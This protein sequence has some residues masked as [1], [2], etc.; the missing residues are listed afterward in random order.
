M[1]RVVERSNLVEAL[2]RVKQNAGSPGVDGMTV[3]DLPTYL[4]DHWKET[5]EQLLVGTYQPKPVRQ[6]EIPKSSGGTR[7]LGIPTVLDRFIQQALLQVLQPI[8]DPTFSPH[9]YGFRPK[10]SAHDAVQAARAYVQ[11][12][13][14]VVVDVDLESFF[15]RVNHDVMM[16]RLA[17]RLADRRLLG[18]IRRF[19]ESGMMVNGVVSE[20][21]EGTPQGGP[22][23]PLLA[24][25]LLDE[26]DKEL[27]RRG[28]AFVRYADDCN[29]YVRS[30]RSGERVMRALRRAYGRLRLRVNETKS[31]VDYAH[32]RTFLSFSFWYGTGGAVRVRVAPKAID[33]MKRRVRELTSR[34]GGRSMQ[35]VVFELSRYLRGWKAYFQLAETRGVFVA[36]DKWI[37]RRL[38]AVQL[39]Q[40]RRG[41]VVYRELAKRGIIPP[42]AGRTA[43]YARYWWRFAASRALSIALPARHFDRMGLPRLAT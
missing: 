6:Q 28:H 27:E 39:H 19:L 42:L 2:R 26:V 25:V 35:S 21:L 40:W 17:K 4:A 23:S 31:A 8:F 9:S 32:K 10:R 33:A 15:D 38:R 34:V 22:L 7:M 16:G 13:R 5:R 3:D 43:R 29:V 1:E 37:R 36:L 18:L 30:M 14:R 24:N 12:G 11:E 20:R 41:R